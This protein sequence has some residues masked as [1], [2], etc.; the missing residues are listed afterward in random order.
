M[1]NS[2]VWDGHSADLVVQGHSVSG[3][4]IGNAQ[5]NSRRI[6]IDGT[7]NPGVGIS[8]QTIYLPDGPVT[9]EEFIKMR[10]EVENWK[11]LKGIIEAHQI[12]EEIPNGD[13]VIRI[14][15][16]KVEHLAMVGQEPKPKDYRVDFGEDSNE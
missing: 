6:S 11:K 4:T 2:K 5:V 1:S 15:R 9:T 10:E 12:I 14:K 16:A 13:I 8:N 3:Q 7:I